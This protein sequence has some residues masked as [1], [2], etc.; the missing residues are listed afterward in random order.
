MD[1]LFYVPISMLKSF[2]ELMDSFL[3]FFQGKYK[4]LVRDEG[5]E[6]QHF[7]GIDLFSFL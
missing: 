5:R 6:D 7:I 1:E 4:N 2:I 3:F